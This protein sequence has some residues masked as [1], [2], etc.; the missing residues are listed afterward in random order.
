[1]NDSSTADRRPYNAAPIIGSPVSD[2]GS[3]ALSTS[4]T[5]YFFE[6]SQSLD[7]L[8]Q[9]YFGH[10]ELGRSPSTFSEVEVILDDGT[11]QKRTVSLST[12]PDEDN[13]QSQTR[14]HREDYPQQSDDGTQSSSASSS[15]ED[16]D[17]DEPFFPA[18][19]NAM[20]RSNAS[21][22]RKAYHL[23]EDD[24]SYSNWW[25]RML[26][27]LHNL[28]AFEFTPRQRL[29]LKCSFAYFTA[30]L[31]TF[32]PA[33]NAFI[34]NNRTSSH[35]VATATVF[36]N[37]AKT[38]GGM[39]EAAAYGWGYV[40]FAV[41]ICLGS[42]I[43]TD[44]FVD[45]G[46][47]NV[48]HLISLLFWLSG[49]TFVIAFLKAHWNKPPVATASSLCFI[50]IFIIVVREG[51]VNRGD[52]D[53]TRIQQITT[54]VA[55]GTVIT[56]ASCILFWPVS[57]AKKLKKD[58]NTTLSS[59]SVLL[60][61]LTKTFLLDNDLPEFKANR[62]LQSA[63]ESHQA[64]F[65][66]L[67]KSLKEAKLERFWNSSI[68][69]KADE[70]D[71]VI[72]SMQRLAQHMGGLRSSCG[73]QF[74]IMG[75]EATK[76]FKELAREK[77]KKKQSQINLF[78]TASGAFNN[79]NVRA[80]YRRR[81]LQEEMRRQRSFFSRS[82]EHL[83][84][85]LKT[86]STTA[87][88]TTSSYA[89]GKTRQNN[90]HDAEGASLV[91]YIQTIRPSVKSFAY[92]C[93]QTLYHLQNDFA[94]TTSVIEKLLPRWSCKGQR[95]SLS[96]LKDNLEKAIILFENAQ[97]QAVKK[98]Y[99]SRMDY[100][101]SMRNADGKLH[102]PE[103]EAIGCVLGEEVI[104]V[105]FFLFNMTEFAREL[106]SLVS[107]VK[108]LNEAGQKKVHL[109]TW[110]V[111]SIKSKWTSK[112]SQQQ[113]GDGVHMND[114]NKNQTHPKRHRHHL[115]SSFIPNERNMMNT[116]HTPLPKTNWR[117]FFIGVWQLF[118]LFK[119]QKMRYA[120]KA[121]IA[122]IILAIPAFYEPTQDWF[123]TYRME[124]ALITLMVVMTPTVGGTNIVA[125]YRIFSTILGCYVA[126]A[127]YMLF[128]ANMY[129]L[130]LLTWLFS[131]PNFYLILNHKHGKFGQFTL[132]AYN[133]VMLNKY[134]DRD[135]NEVAVWL[136]ATQ[137][138]F[139]IL[140][141]V[142]FGLVATAYVWPYEAR[143]EL[144]KGL[145]DF[146][147]R[148][149]WLYQRLVSIYADYPL[150]HKKS[151][152][153]PGQ[154]QQQQNVIDSNTHASETQQV[155]VEAQRRLATQTF[156]DL[157]LGLQ[158]TLLDLQALLSQTPNEPRLKGPFPVD[159]YRT[160]LSSCQNILDRFLSM[161]TVMLKEAW[162]DEVQHD[163]MTPV[164]HERKE[165]VGNVLLYLYLLASALRLKTPMPPY[166]PPARKAWKALLDQ[167]VEMPIAKSKRILEKDNAYVFYYCYVTLMEDIIRE[168][169]K[170]SYRHMLY[171]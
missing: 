107:A 33:L 134:N 112:K 104:L 164:A 74:E 103:S 165:M 30:S 52:F 57:A 141:G 93:K 145:S 51:S 77:K 6:R 42:M 106:I 158:R 109:W 39:V 96:V 20:N 73:I 153:E 5:N 26:V 1:M 43:T 142:V 139:A 12:Q 66:S 122:T 110:M 124:W 135:T 45:R 129:V 151:S 171:F 49:A 29:V 25:S 131:I 50:T 59:Y 71:Q 79:W 144:R 34:G 86:R 7:A 167:L 70:Y 92:T 64:S 2:P 143:T 56:V 99:L 47:F 69:A 85:I 61:L 48:A 160:M 44:Y 128:P 83:N 155:A 163:F 161:R 72:H 130:P 36:F 55:M 88:P 154:Q 40:T 90:Y 76:K 162:Y 98:L 16:N 3:P 32:I 120:I 28:F 80:G 105:Y 117:R 159:T 89:R 15:S 31:F 156:M 111:S 119:L 147:L 53:T 137:R 148:L 81:K 116:L 82:D 170:V 65:T 166:F 62:T 75:S 41:F 150:N 19:T 113:E 168:L 54:A 38:L 17:S 23:V 132:L 24:H 169:D 91:K 9:D 13:E 35:L 126:M 94:A 27:I 100:I 102:N 68:R 114:K 123:R 78:S 18:K 21:Y 60:K 101:S 95:P 46:Y 136:L 4:P 133:L 8:Q 115:M 84:H 118:S 87:I 140:V 11:T 14:I 152:D 37:P 63:I 125:I 146:L 10:H 58:L 121:M 67:Q 108:K 127:F 157:E 149:S 138:C 22:K 97:K